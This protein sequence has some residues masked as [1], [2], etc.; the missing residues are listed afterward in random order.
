MKKG[1]FKKPFE[2]CLEKVTYTQKVQRKDF[3]DDG[4]Y[5]VVSQEESF[6]NG[7]W[8]NEAD[9]FKVKTPIVIFGDHTKVLKYI[10][11]D[12]VLGADGVKILPPRDFLV[13]KF[14]FYQLQNANL[15][16]LGYARHYKLLKELVILYPARPEQQRIVKIL[17]EAFAGIATAQANAAKNLQN[18]RDLFASHLNAVFTHRG[19]GW[20]EKRFDEFCLLQRGFDLPTRERIAGKYPLVSSSGIIDTH[21]KA[22][23]CGPGV[24]TGRSGSIGNVFFIK[25]DYWPLNTTLFVKEFFGNDIRFTYWLL[26]YFKLL[27]FASGTGVPTLNRNAVH[28]QPVIVPACCD[29]QKAIAAQLDALSSE[30]RRLAAIYQRKQAALSEFK[31]SLLHRAFAGEL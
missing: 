13:P 19:A 8:D 9:L 12:F 15:E 29:K 16:T 27:R 11:F 6:I 10:D 4:A 30:T 28:E 2:D 23:V 24:V 20:V 7:Y 25:E 31:Q 18:A 3:L 22:P 1:W 5:P 14:F 17:D 26:N 21:N